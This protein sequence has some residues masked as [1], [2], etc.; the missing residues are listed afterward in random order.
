MAN[1]TI[2]VLN[3]LGYQE[4][5]QSAD[6]LLIGSTL[7]ASSTGTFAGDLT[8]NAVN[9]ISAAGD[10]YYSNGNLIVGATTIGT[11]DSSVLGS[12]GLTT[13]NRSN[14]ADVCFL[15]QQQGVDKVTIK[16]DG[17]VNAVSFTG[18]G[19]NLT[20]LAATLQEVTSNGNTTSTGATF[21]GNITT[22]ASS[23][24]ATGTWIQQNGGVYTVRAA[25]STNPV[26]T[27]GSI[28]ATTNIV[29]SANGAGTFVG[30]VQAG[31][32]AS[33]GTAVGAKLSNSGY[34]HTTR[35]SDTDTVYA[36]YKQGNSTPT[37]LIK[38]NGDVSFAGELSADS[39]DCGTY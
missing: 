18:D 34:V 5:L 7:Q 31:G 14:G 16:A 37:T 1:R 29:L 32:N 13:V 39:I 27:G 2:T 30:E 4:N 8:I 38:A 25:S 11:N 19:S 24:S 3:P 15:A 9:K 33:N 12:N 28:G 36:G 26:F 21:G 23:G 20:G 10:S 17:S 6:N 22:G 35:S